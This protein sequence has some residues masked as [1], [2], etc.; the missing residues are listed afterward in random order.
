M[1]TPETTTAATPTATSPTTPSPGDPF[2]VEPFTI[3]WDVFDHWCS[4][5][6]DVV[7]DEL[8]EDAL[9]TALRAQLDTVAAMTDDDAH[10]WFTE[11]AALAATSDDLALRDVVDILEE[12]AAALTDCPESCSCA[13]DAYEGYGRDD[14]DTQLAT[15]GDH[16][17]VIT[18]DHTWSRVSADQ[19]SWIVQ[20]LRHEE[21]IE[22]K[23]TITALADIQTSRSGWGGM[24]GAWDGRTLTITFNDHGP[25]AE[26]T[27]TPLTEEMESDRDFL[28]EAGA[29]PKE[30]DVMVVAYP[31]QTITETRRLWNA[32]EDD[33]RD[34]FAIDDVVRDVH[35]RVTQTPGIAA[36]HLRLIAP[37][38]HSF[39]DLLD[40]LVSTSAPAPS[41]H[42]AQNAAAV[43]TAP[44][45]AAA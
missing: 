6:V 2:T 15:L 1:P 34:T 31:R 11:Q 5:G 42:D 37:G 8:D 33:D 19:Y 16:T 36:A 14:L 3:G 27:A 26:L 32:L 12:A 38:W 43:K 39:G 29:Y 24:T 28:E 45:P 9:P 10:H 44:V 30:A 4:R 20:N 17:W 41:A 18:T 21:R 35:A 23:L 25:W 40:A 22:G 7:L 13:Y